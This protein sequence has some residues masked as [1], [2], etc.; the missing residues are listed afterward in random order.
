MLEMMFNNLIKALQVTHREIEISKAVELAQFLVN[1]GA[2]GKSPVVGYV[3][4]A[5][6]KGKPIRALLLVE[7]ELPQ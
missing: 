4:H 3:A 2:Q 7:G 6:W 1:T 5:S